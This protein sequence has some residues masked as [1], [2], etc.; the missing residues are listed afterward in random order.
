MKQITKEITEFLNNFKNKIPSTKFSMDTKNFLKELFI[1]MKQ[2]DE[3]YEKHKSK[4]E[5]NVKNNIPESNDFN[6]MPSNIRN[7]INAMNGTCYEY[8]FTINTKKYKVFH[9]K[10]VFS[11]LL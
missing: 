2:G 6:Y 4:I 1:L 3:Y 5:I 9:K 10:T 8:N 7:S 11:H